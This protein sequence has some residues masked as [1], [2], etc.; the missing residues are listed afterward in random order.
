MSPLVVIPKSD[1]HV[2]VSLDMRRVNKA[3]RRE[4]HPILT[5]EELYG[6]TMFRKIWFLNGV[7]NVN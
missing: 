4:R 7:D 6:S 3:I 2:R 5:V 1:R